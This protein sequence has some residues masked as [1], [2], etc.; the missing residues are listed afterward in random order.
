M[1]ASK[2]SFFFV[3][4]TAVPLYSMCDAWE[5]VSSVTNG[6]SQIT[7][8]TNWLW[9]VNGAKQIYRCARPC[10]GKWVRVDG[11]LTQ[12]DA[13]DE[14][15]WGTNGNAIYKRPVDGSGRWKRI[16]GGLK[17]VSPSGNGYVWGV[18]SGDHIFKCKKPC[19]GQWKGVD[20][21]LSQIDGGYAFVYGVNRGGQAF[22]RSID[23]TTGWRH[24]PAPVRLKFISGSGYKDLFAISTTGDTYRCAKPCVGDWEKMSTNFNSLSQCDASYDAVFGVTSGGTVFRHKTGK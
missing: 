5:V 17:H 13:G 16:G 19:N 15:V 4:L 20:G 23:G 10:T 14:E 12:V 2:V 3:L 1:A 22:R 8:S 6:H 7:G 24:I 9:S 11:Q 21:R 18:N